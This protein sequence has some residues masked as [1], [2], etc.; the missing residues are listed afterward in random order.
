VALDELHLP[1]AMKAT[2]TTTR[3]GGNG[4]ADAGQ[5]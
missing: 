5:K 2:K 4:T 1:Q 3:D